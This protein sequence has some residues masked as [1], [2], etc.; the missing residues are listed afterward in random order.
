MVNIDCNDSSVARVCQVLEQ[1]DEYGVK[2]V[3]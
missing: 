2:N 3:G 1:S